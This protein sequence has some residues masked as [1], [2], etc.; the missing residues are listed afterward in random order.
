MTTNYPGDTA[1]IVS[2]FGL[3]E[4]PRFVPGYARTDAVIHRV[5]LRADSGGVATATFDGLLDAT[6]C[7]TATNR[8]GTV[9][10][11]AEV[12]PDDDRE[13]TVRVAMVPTGKR[14]PQADTGAE[15]IRLGTEGRIHVYLLAVET[16]P[17]GTAEALEVAER[18]AA[19]ADALLALN[20]DD[21]GLSGA[22]AHLDDAGE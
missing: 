21:D 7:F 10:L 2:T 19:E 6:R 11:Y 18:A 12:T 5:G 8:R 17:A 20:S 16:N 4:R 14:V 13:T 1:D 3:D 22:D 9:S 15:S